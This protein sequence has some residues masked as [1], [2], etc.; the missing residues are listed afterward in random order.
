MQ[1]AVVGC[2]WVCPVTAS[3][4]PGLRADDPCVDH[5][6]NTNTCTAVAEHG[7]DQVCPFAPV[8][9]GR[10]RVFDLCG[11]N[12]AD[13]GSLRPSCLEPLLGRRCACVHLIMTK[14]NCLIRWPAMSG[15]KFKSLS[16]HKCGA[17][18]MSKDAIGPSAARDQWAWVL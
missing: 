2:S 18:R 4:I 8:Q 12:A 7:Q 11:S 1:G 3:E 9:R 5:C 17:G 15:I 16:A 10:Q 6:I 13:D 14:G